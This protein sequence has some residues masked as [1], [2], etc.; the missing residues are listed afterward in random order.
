MTDTNPTKTPAQRAKKPAQARKDSIDIDDDEDQQ[1]E[2]VVDAPTPID[3]LMNALDAIDG[4][5]RE[6]RIVVSRYNGARVEYLDDFVAAGFSERVVKERFGGGKYQVKAHRPGGAYLRS[7]TIVIA[8]EPKQEAPTPPA[9]PTAPAAQA[10]ARDD[11]RNDAILMRMMDTM[12]ADARAARTE[13]AETQR[14]MFELMSKQ[15][16]GAAAE[17][18]DPFAQLM[19]I[20]EYEKS[21]RAE[22][23]QDSKGHEPPAEPSWLAAV[24]PYIPLLL[25]K[26][27]PGAAT[28]QAQTG[29]TPPP[30]A[31][32]ASTPAAQATAAQPG[33]PATTSETTLPTGTPAEIIA[34]VLENFGGIIVRCAKVKGDTR[35]IANVISESIEAEGEVAAEFIGSAFATA[36]PGEA[37][38]AFIAKH[39]ELKDA[40][41]WLGEVESEIRAYFLGDE[42]EA[43]NSQKAKS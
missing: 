20:R 29:I 16:G 19:R 30:A 34:G 42:G 12:A 5:G 36:K 1:T 27:A 18:V 37:A 43:S 15:R 21:I 25:A 39:A 17:P 3:Q 35:S 41:A 7:V 28:Q 26:I 10:A 22:V 23:E 32:A 31:A 8:G 9:A 13:A 33:E 40:A 24:A 14:R 6:G 4:D 2:T 38:A 11:A